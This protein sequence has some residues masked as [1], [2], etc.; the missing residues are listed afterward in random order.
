MTTDTSVLV[1]SC[2]KYQDIWKPFFTL[3]F[4]YWHD[5]PYPIYLGSNQ[6]IYADQRVKT[7]AVGD[8]K[9]WSSGFRK[10]LEQIPQPYDFA[11]RRLSIETAGGWRKNTGT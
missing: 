7:I 10:M 6:R 5:C 8:D 11:F 1:V 2:D 9:D 4:R 3:F